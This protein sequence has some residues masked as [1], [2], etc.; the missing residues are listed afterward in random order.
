MLPGCYSDAAFLGPAEFLGR[1]CSLPSIGLASP[2]GRPACLCSTASRPCTSLNMLFTAVESP[3]AH[4]YLNCFLATP[5]PHHTM[6][7]V[8]HPSLLFTGAAQRRGAQPHSV[9]GWLRPP[10]HPHPGHRA[11]FRGVW[12]PGGE[13]QAHQEG[14]WI[15]GQPQGVCAAAGRLPNPT[16]G[17]QYMERAPCSAAALCPSSTHL[18]SIISPAALRGQDELSFV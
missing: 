4:C 15:A 12:P 11:R 9:C 18:I 10:L 7:T 3:T 16:Q 13:L 2:A 1:A 5:R 14:L 8:P 17:L 6:L